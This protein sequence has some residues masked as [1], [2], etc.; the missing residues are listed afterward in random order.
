MYMYRLDTIFISGMPKLQRNRLI[1][2]IAENFPFFFVMHFS[3]FLLIHPPCS[4]ILGFS[5]TQNV[6]HE[7]WPSSKPENE[8]QWSERKST[9][10]YF[11]SVSWNYLL[12]YTALRFTDWT[13]VRPQHNRS[14]LLWGR[15]Y[16]CH[17]T[18][19][20]AH[21]YPLVWEKKIV[22]FLTACPLS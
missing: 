16:P 21:E 4:W 3:Q 11:W 18:P 5:L 1:L 10:I 15:S 2:Y 22:A 8:I 13:I 7:Y 6:S 20:F 17:L 12:Q 9:F 19:L 14:V